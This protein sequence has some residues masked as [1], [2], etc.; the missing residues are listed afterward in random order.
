MN[1]NDFFESALSA[2]YKKAPMT[3]DDTFMRIVKERAKNMKKNDNVRQVKFTE[4]TPEYAEPK[5]SHKALNVF[6]GVAGTAAVLTGAMFGLKWLNDNGGLKGPDVRGPGA[7]Y[8]EDVEPVQ[9]TAVPE[10]T[11]P[12]VTEENKDEET[13]LACA[14]SG[15]DER[16]FEETDISYDMAGDIYAHIS[17]YSYDGLMLIVKYELTYPEEI[18]DY[19]SYFPTLIDRRETTGEIT[20][21]NKPR[22]SRFISIDGNKVT[23]ERYILNSFADDSFDTLF[24]DQFTAPWDE[25]FNAAK[26]AAKSGKYDISV[27][28]T[29]PDSPVIIRDLSEE[30]PEYTLPDG[31]VIE[32][33]KLYIS[34]YGVFIDFEQ[35]DLAAW[36]ELCPNMQQSAITLT[37]NDGSEII[38][39]SENNWGMCGKDS[40]NYVG[41]LF[42]ETIDTRNVVSVN[43]LGEQFVTFEKTTSFDI[44][45][46]FD[47]SPLSGDFE[48]L[49]YIDGELQDDL[50]ETRAISEMDKLHWDVS[51]TGVHTYKVDI[52]SLEKGSSGTL[53]EATVDF[54]K[55]EPEKD[56]HDSF[57][58]K[59]FKQLVEQG[60]TPEF[61]EAIGNGNGLYG[62]YLD[63]PLTGEEAW[64]LVKERGGIDFDYNLPYDKSLFTFTGAAFVIDYADCDV[65]AIV[66]GTVEY[67][68]WYIGW[69]QTILL[70]D[71]NGHYWLYGHLGEVSVAEG[72]KVESGEKIGHTGTSGLTDHQLFAMRVG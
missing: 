54:S 5:N 39:R 17:G 69:G 66:G 57:N 51:G 47:D 45:F 67:A 30:M 43:I 19:P 15:I 38:I 10:E 61:P 22:N 34:A 52:V 60:D 62:E 40:V 35:I 58:G 37:M 71:E 53:F 46:N 8:H 2:A 24:I 72:D 44:V 70:H 49:Y 68:G 41:G 31:K 18:T 42:D 21:F 29:F 32:P 13:R 28:K 27:H 11:E 12:A 7:G 3:D 64:E 33:E 36:E 4:I 48:F 20:Y 65:T 23:I 14:P 16:Y 56:F 25:E 63:T 50:T 6:A 9:S 1:Y 26:E 55:E 59:I